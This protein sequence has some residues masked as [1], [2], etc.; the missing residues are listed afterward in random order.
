M[1]KKSPLRKFVISDNAFVCSENL[2]TPFSGLDEY[3]S[4][5][6]IQFLFESVEDPYEKTFG[7][8]TK[9]GESYASLY[10][11]ALSMLER[12]F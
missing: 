6:C 8:M 11:R 3:A 7:M 9:G 12:Y 4:K 2:L 5:G 1:I 10:R